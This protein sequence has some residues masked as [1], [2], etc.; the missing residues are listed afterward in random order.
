M[1]PDSLRVAGFGNAMLSDVVCTP[2]KVWNARPSQDDK[3]DALITLEQEKALI[4]SQRSVI[5]YQATVLVNYSRS[6]TG[7][8]VPP[9]D[10]LSFLQRFITLGDE[11]A[12]AVI[13]LDARLRAVEKKIQNEID[14]PT[15]KAQGHHSRYTKVKLT[16]SAEEDHTAEISLT[17]RESHTDNQRLES[18]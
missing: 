8:H 11:N 7:E 9:E 14:E 15:T 5:D 6:L 13:E 4:K 16:I 18:N 12:K 1:V 17:Y 2:P 3:S 10:M